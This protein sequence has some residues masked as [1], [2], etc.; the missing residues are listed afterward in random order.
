M[1]GQPFPRY[2]SSGRDAGGG[3]GFKI[4]S[5]GISSRGR[6]GSARRISFGDCVG[7]T[8][9]ARKIGLFSSGVTGSAFSP[10][11]SVRV[12]T[13][14]VLGVVLVVV[15]GWTGSAFR[16]GFVGSGRVFGSAVTGGLSA[17]GFSTGFGFTV[18]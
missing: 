2:C 14:S 17:S 12:S 15:S 5:S 7:V 4:D 11:L 1:T 9:T 13:D 8:G 6:T 18:E 10:G 16:T 3:V